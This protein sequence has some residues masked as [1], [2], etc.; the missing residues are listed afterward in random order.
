MLVKIMKHFILS[1][2][3]LFSGIV[4]AQ[5]LEATV[6]TVPKIFSAKD[7]VKVIV[8]VSEVTEL[9]DE[10]SLYL[11]AWKNKPGGRFQNGSW[12][13]SSELQRLTKEGKGVFT[14]KIVPNFLYDE[15]PDSLQSIQ[16]L[17]K[18]KN[19]LGN[20][21]TDD[22]VLYLNGQSAPAIPDNVQT[23]TTLT[24]SV[25]GKVVSNPFLSKFSVN[26]APY[27]MKV[28]QLSMIIDQRSE[29]LYVLA[30]LM[31][32]PNATPANELYYVQD[33]RSYFAPFR[34][35]SAVADLER[36]WNKGIG[37]DGPINIFLN[38]DNQFKLLPTTPK[39]LIEKVGGID[40]MY[41]FIANVKQFYID[42]KFASFFH[43]HQPFY[44]RVLATAAYNFRNFNVIRLM[45]Q[46]YGQKQYAYHLILNLLN[47][48]DNFSVISGRGAQK[49][50]YA[51]IS[52]ASM[53]LSGELP[54]LKPSIL[55]TE[56][57]IHEFSHAF[58]NQLIDSNHQEVMKYAGL[59]KH[60]R[61]SMQGQGY[62]DWSISVK[63]HIVRAVT[64]RIASYFYGKELADRHF[65]DQQICQR[66]IYIEAITKELER[67]ES[68][69]TS[70]P[71]FANFFPRLI[72]SFETIDKESIARLQRKVKELRQPE[73]ASIPLG[74]SFS[75]DTNT[76]IIVSTHESDSLGQGSVRQ[77]TQQF[78]QL[79]PKPFKMLTDDEALNSDLSQ[80]NILVVGTPNGNSFLKKWITS[81]PVVIGDDQVITNKILKG[82][83]FQLVLC[84]VN[85]FNKDKSMIVYTAQQ[86][87]DIANYF[88]SSFKGNTHYWV[89]EKLSTVDRGNFISYMG[90]WLPEK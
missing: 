8:D 19:G 46:Y 87:K 54:I 43:S 42:S 25:I 39:Y 59:Y 22:I 33:V 13:N 72:K 79:F 90:H 40:S 51:V 58:V 17:V 88:W 15:H 10:D 49:E 80:K 35:H 70:Y 27:Q 60:I 47:Y 32:Y 30:F 23:N 68:Q 34:N 24:T 57:I 55:N 78:I 81:I 9:A 2:F 73:V 18:A 20:K 61:S 69:R 1:C 11:W 16:F 53:V 4:K 21:Q 37:V 41:R 84:W 66:F 75:N 74:G 89:A 85:P 14:I 5:N 7:T 82:K 44:Q 67:Y 31:G 77:Y 36:F 56:L 48:G 52:S 38:L 76:V 6:R 62:Q 3:L 50:L 12:E 63:E 45:E 83:K 29:L 71:R 86:A 28:N 64:N 26:L 65:Y